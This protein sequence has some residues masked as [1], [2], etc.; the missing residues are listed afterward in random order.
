MSRRARTTALSL[1][2][3]LLAAAVVLAMMLPVPYV[4]LS[5]GPVYDALSDVDGEP[6]VSVDGADTY[7]TTGVL[8]IT[9]VYEK[10]SP[11]SRLTLLEA[12]RGW[13]ASSDDVLPRDLLFP[14][15]AFDGDDAGD[16]FQQQGRL[17]MEE[18]EQNAVVAALR[19]VG[20]PVTIEVVVDDTQPDTPADGVLRHGDVVLAI[21]G[22]RIHS[23]RDV[24]RAMSDV[25]P[26]DDVTLRIRRQ[27]EQREERIR[28]VA[29]PDD[30]ERAY[31]GVLLTL[32]YRSPVDVDLALGNVGGPSAGLMFSLAIV[33]TLTPDS[34]TGGSSVAGTGTITPQGRVGPIGGIVQKMYGAA[35]EGA[36]L[37]LAPR[38]NCAEVVGNEPDG[39]KVVPVR[40]LDEA[41]DVLA[42][43][44]APAPC[45]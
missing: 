25:D 14:P 1:T 34:L 23:Y 40:T 8:G 24:Q 3:A 20:A 18:S 31:L 4:R 33:D 19:Q 9:T 16:Q 38:S 30:P 45:D 42:G 21:D 27:G 22:A 29:N 7:P 15:D 2:F 43:D 12:M 37:F 17:E 28:T 6:V 44:A 10:G 13:L 35:S 11:G 32:G 36:T 39:L 41:V 5:P 26:G